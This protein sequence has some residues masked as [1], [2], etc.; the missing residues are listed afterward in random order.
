MTDR[1]RQRR[2]RR[3]V[4]GLTGIIAVMIGLV[5]I[6]VPLYRLFCS[7]TGYGGTTQRVTGDTATVS[8]RVIT[9]RFNTDIAPGLA[10]HFTPVQR[11]VT[12]HLGEEALVFFRAENLSDKPLVGHAAFNVTPEQ[13]GIYFKKIQCFCFS[14]ERLNAGQSV[15]MPVDFYVDPALARDVDIH[16]LDT[17]T[18]SYTFFPSTAPKDAEDLS[19]FDPAAAADPARGAQVFDE[20][21]G[22]CHALAKNGV[23]P[24]LGDVV[25]RSVGRIA[26]YDYS[27]ALRGATI[28]W[29]PE[30]LERWLADPPALLPGTRMPVKV[31][32]PGARRDVIAFLAAQGEQRSAGR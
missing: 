15:D 5:A 31:L 26:G 4:A 7:V 1:R 29:T 22:G 16:D 23:G 10:W 17:I 18:L 21:C 14:D 8:D 9:V 30:V 28:T 27:P 11:S 20:R 32:E 13:A 6:S 19:R 3:V 24:E 25:G 2:N 12:L